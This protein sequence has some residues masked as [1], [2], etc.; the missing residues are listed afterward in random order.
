MFIFAVALL[1]R[2]AWVAT[3]RNELAW[4][5]EQEFVEVAQHIAHGDG[6]VSTSFRAN[7]ILPYYLGVVFRFFGNHYAIARIG[8]AIVGAATCVLIYRIGF[9]LMGPLTGALAGMLLALYPPHIYLAGVLYVDCW[10][11]FF[12]ALSVYLAALTLQNRGHLGLA[13]LCGISLGLTTLTRAT[14]LTYIPCVC[15]AWL[16]AGR[17]PWR[18]SAAACAALL[19]ACALTI[20]PWTIRNYSVYGRPIL[21]STGFYTMLWRGNNVLANGGPDDRHLTWY[22]ELWQ[23][24]LRQLPE[25]EQIALSKQYDRINDAVEA[26]YKEIGDMYL[27]TD[28][29][30]RP[31]AIDSLFANPARTA[32]LMMTKLGT[33]FS[34]F[35]GTETNNTFTEVRNRWFAAVSFYPIMLLAIVGGWIGL[36][37]RRELA[38]IYLLIV[39]IVGSYVLLTVCTRFRLPLDPYFILFASLT[40]TTGTPMLVGEER[41]QRLRA[42]FGVPPEWASAVTARIDEGPSSGVGFGSGSLARG[43]VAKGRD[44]IRSHEEHQT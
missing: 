23:D 26:R 9:M 33:L 35:S 37:R 19:V 17:W 8:Q 25:A 5:D 31:A 43:P 32:A 20:M 7:P 29:V 28:E 21:V 11:T 18:R 4:I 10:L 39:S 14:F 42:R 1:A 2:L 15:A 34:A 22:N 36:P 16:Y 30:L 6:Y 40:L 44:P 12:C 24:R 13:M 27:A 41:V 3:L 38:L